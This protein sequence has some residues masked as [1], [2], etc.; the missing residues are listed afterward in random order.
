MNNVWGI[1]TTKQTCSGNF[2][3]WT[4]RWSM[5]CLER[6][7]TFYLPKYLIATYIVEITSG[8]RVIETIAS[9]CTIFYRT[10]CKTKIKKS[11]NIFHA[12]NSVIL[13]QK[14][15]D[16]CFQEFSS[17]GKLAIHKIATNPVK[18]QWK[19]IQIHVHKKILT[20]SPPTLMV[21]AWS[22]GEWHYNNAQTM[23]T[24]REI[25]TEKELNRNI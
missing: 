13:T 3:L 4:S 15:F 20:N 17:S 8:W 12:N 1:K 19:S 24:K 25:W 9:F 22:C 2:R 11:H 7:A 16:Q 23:N 21:V 18:T 14:M 6:I 10:P 5:R